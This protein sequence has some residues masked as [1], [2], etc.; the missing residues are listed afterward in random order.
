MLDHDPLGL[1]GGTGREEHIGKPGGWNG[2]RP[3][4]FP[5]NPSPA[6]VGG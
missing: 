3:I 4:N 2:L 6:S 1:A 5:S